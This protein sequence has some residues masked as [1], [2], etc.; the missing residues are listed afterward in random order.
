MKIMSNYTRSHRVIIIIL[1]LI[2][3][4]SC[5]STTGNSMGGPCE[6]DNDC[7]DDLTC[8]TESMGFPGGYCSKDCSSDWMVCDSSAEEGCSGIGFAS[9]I[10][11]KKKDCEC[12]EGYICK[13]RACR[14]ECADTCDFQ[15]DDDNI[16]DCV[17]PGSTICRPALGFTCGEPAAEGEQ[18]VYPVE[19]QGYT[20]TPDN[21]YLD[22]YCLGLDGGKC[23]RI[24]HYGEPCCSSQDCE[25]LCTVQSE[26]ECDHYTRCDGYC[27]IITCTAALQGTCYGSVGDPCESDDDCFGNCF[28]HPNFPGGYCASVAGPGL[29]LGDSENY[30]KYTRTCRTD[31]DC[32]RE[33]YTCKESA[34][35]YSSCWP[36]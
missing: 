33:G 23:G 20:F 7:A 29:H 36:L 27:P 17:C 11:C 15:T 21:Q 5:N 16:I 25:A 13:D 4:S 24:S 1:V 8:F 19:C 2:L 31:D 26:T 18:C 3:A 32:N 10:V 34:Y 9:Y 22:H 14:I 12:R 6:A 28:K 35:D 30:P